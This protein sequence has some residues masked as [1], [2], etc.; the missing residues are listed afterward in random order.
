MDDL[1]AAGYFV[2]EMCNA[3]RLIK[4]GENGFEN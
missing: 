1:K 4:T 3:C 2:K